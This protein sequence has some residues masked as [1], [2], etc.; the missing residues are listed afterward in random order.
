M[1]DAPDSFGT[2]NVDIEISCPVETRILSILRSF[3]T[4]L[5]REVGFSS[6]QTADIELAVDEACANVIRH[7][8]K[9]IGVSSDI[10]SGSRDHEASKACVLRLR[11]QLGDEYLR[12]CIIDSGIGLDNT[13]GGCNSVEEYTQRAAQGGRGGLGSYIIRE[14]MDEVSYESPPGS[15]TILTMT[16]YLRTPDSPAC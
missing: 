16:K 14:F 6:E 10:D 3:V 15:G 11:A 4:A 13:P 12:I 8:Y 2:G 9:H 7:A 5:S 1:T